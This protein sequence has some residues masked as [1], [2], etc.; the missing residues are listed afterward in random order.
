L[1]DERQSDERLDRVLIDAR[2]LTQMQEK[3]SPGGEIGVG[4]FVERAVLV[5]DAAGKPSGTSLSGGVAR[6]KTTTAT[7]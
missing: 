1:E 6:A 3:R 2:S 4:A 7:R 5:R